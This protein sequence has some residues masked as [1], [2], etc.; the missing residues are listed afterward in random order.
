MAAVLQT[1]VLSKR[2]SKKWALKDCTLSVP[3]RSMTGLVGLNG[4]G[5]TTL[6]HLALGLIEPSTGNVEVLGKPVGAQNERYLLPRI[7]FVAQRHSLNCC[8]AGKI[9]P[10]ARRLSKTCSVRVLL[11]TDREFFRTH[12]YFFK[13][14]LYTSLND[15]AVWL[16]ANNNTWHGDRFV[17]IGL[18]PGHQIVWMK[19]VCILT[20]VDH[21]HTPSL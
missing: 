18:V 8:A 16:L 6:I 9:Y 17:L 14:S 15:N 4:A 12:L 13:Y 3:A 10:A 5:K 1:N 21:L 7:G 11:L 20:Y 19:L 2:Y